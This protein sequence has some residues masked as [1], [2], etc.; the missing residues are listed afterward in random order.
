MNRRLLQMALAIGACIGA[1]TA[2]PEG[3]TDTPEWQLSPEPTLVIG[4][5]ST[6]ETTFGAIGGVASLPSGEVAVVDRQAAEIRVFGPDGGYRRT[7][8]RRG[9]GPG[10]FE[11]ILWIQQAGD[12]L[13]VRE[14]ERGT[15]TVLGGDGG[16]Y[17][18]VPRGVDSAGRSISLTRR[19]PGGRWLAVIDA[20]WVNPG[21]D[22]FRQESVTV[23]ML[24]PDGAPPFVP[25]ARLG[26]EPLVLIPATRTFDFSRFHVSGIP[27]L[28]GNRVA[29]I[30]PDTGV[31]RLFNDAGAAVG[32]FKIPMPRRA[33]T[34][35]MVSEVLAWDESAARTDRIRAQVARFVEAEP[36]P[37]FLPMLRQAWADG[38]DTLWFLEFDLD[39][40]A[41]ERYH[42]VRD[43]G[44]LLGVLTAP[45]RFRLREVGPDWVL[46][47]R[48]DQDGVEQV[49]RY[50]LTR[51]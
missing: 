5:D 13:L 45:P 4:S 40:S 9:R 22:A 11:E 50:A 39:L 14:A 3:P 48:T 47:V 23:G 21:L 24:G 51:R 30:Y 37:V 19:L 46:G 35:A 15:V 49:V 1:C 42:I 2:A 26:G 34:D 25:L 38:D 41:P 17:R 20:P 27:L 44:I 43:D 33:L 28:V 8:A 6:P 18:I 36:K 31:V 16:A 7:I 32:E 10:E 29:L 12:T